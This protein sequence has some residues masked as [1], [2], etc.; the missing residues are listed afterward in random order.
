MMI[1]DIQIAYNVIL[2]LL[3]VLN[4][5]KNRLEKLRLEHVQNAKGIYNH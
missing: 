1:Q 2:Q 4:A 5:I 3:Y